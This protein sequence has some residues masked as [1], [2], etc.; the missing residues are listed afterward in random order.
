MK[1]KRLTAVALSL[2]MSL[3][4][5][6]SAS[7][8]AVKAAEF[9][10]FDSGAWYAEAVSAAVDNGLLIGRDHG[11]LSPN[12]ILTRAEM[13]MV[14]DRAFGAYKTADVSKFNDVSPQSWY[15]KSIQMAVQM[16]TYEGTGA[17][18]MSPDCPISRQEIMT[19][20]CRALQL[21]TNRY[22]D[23]DLSQFPDADKVANWALPYV[24]AM[25]GA[26]Y[27]Q[28]RDTGLVP[29]ANT[30]RAEFAQMFH[31]IIKEYV[32]LS[33]S[34]TGN[35]T[36]NLLIRTDDVTL[37]DM[38]IDGDLIIGCGAADGKVTLS[39]VTVTGRVVVW[40]GG[41]EAVYMNDGTNV[42][43]LVVCRVDGPVKVIFDR[44]STLKVYDHIVVTIT[45]RAAAYE[46]TEVI[47]Y[48]ISGILA[49]QDKV[50][51]MVTENQIAVSIPAHLYATVD[52]TTVMTEI[53]NYGLTD[54]YTVELRWDDTGEI[55]VEPFQVEPG[56]TRI[57]IALTQPLPLGDYPCTAII[58]AERDGQTTGALELAVTIHSAHLWNA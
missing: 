12:G 49:E 14:I 43:E 32:T 33:G 13:A 42:D 38:T 1:F 24:K 56:D 58:T 31:N 22:A 27:I 21:D 9:P 19:V 18:T 20:L 16:G 30:T 3:G 37:H 54:R 53:I 39:N 15:Y 35:R 57:A 5:I 26:G 50:D 29:A 28:G 48:D 46:D 51:D 23:T 4:L 8:A 41:T 11:L 40:G 55:I 44:D 36:G 10:D 7:A 25:V 34:Y 52:S 47:F 17:S 45:A 6:G 2:V